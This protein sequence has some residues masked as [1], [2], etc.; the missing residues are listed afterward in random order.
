MIIIIDV[1]FIYFFGGL[2]SFFFFFFFFVIPFF[3]VRLFFALFLFLLKF[4]WFFLLLIVLLFVGFLLMIIALP[5]YG[6]LHDSFI[7]SASYTLSWSFW[8]CMIIFPLR[9]TLTI[10]CIFAM[11]LFEDEE[12]W[13]KQTN[14]NRLVYIFLFQLFLQ[15]ALWLYTGCLSTVS[16]LFQLYHGDYLYSPGTLKARIFVA[17]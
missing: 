17:N 10:V 15:L 3:C 8:I 11:P 6:S 14:Y 2:L 7:Y 13:W 9:V 1:V 5:V 12:Y 16:I 4:C